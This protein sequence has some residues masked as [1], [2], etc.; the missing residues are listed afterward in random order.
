MARA[1]V[2]KVKAVHHLPPKRTRMNITTGKNCYYIYADKTCDTLC[3]ESKRYYSNADA[4][5]GAISWCKRNGYANYSIVDKP[6]P[7]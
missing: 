6:K 4:Q 1:L 5:R 2:N 7:N 3:V